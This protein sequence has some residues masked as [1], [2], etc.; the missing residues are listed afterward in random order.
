METEPKANLCPDGRL[1]LCA[2]L[3]PGFLMVAVV[4]ATLIF[5]HGIKN[6]DS[7]AE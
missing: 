2:D 7:L 6:D 4:D 3:L 5:A 1:R